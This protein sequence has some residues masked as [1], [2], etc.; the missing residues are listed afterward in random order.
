MR[1]LVV[2][3]HVQLDRLDN[4]QHAERNLGFLHIS[5]VGL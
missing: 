1:V 3:G 4:H 5:Q 2:L